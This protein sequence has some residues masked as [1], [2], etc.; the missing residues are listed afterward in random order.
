LLVA[1]PA[2]RPPYAASSIRR[3]DSRWSP[4]AAAW[5]AKANETVKA[6]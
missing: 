1:P 3:P 5:N 6:T 2:K 4:Y